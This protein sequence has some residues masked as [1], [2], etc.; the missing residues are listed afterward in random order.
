MAGQRHLR[1][2][3]A[4]AIV[5][6][7][8]VMVGFTTPESQMDVVLAVLRDRFAKAT[9]EDDRLVVEVLRVFGQPESAVWAL[10]QEWC[11]EYDRDAGTVFEHVW[12]P[13]AGDVEGADGG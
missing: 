11:R 12:A 13:D 8:L 10:L 7:A 2:V 5:Q 4:A 3:E 6:N 9:V 1:P